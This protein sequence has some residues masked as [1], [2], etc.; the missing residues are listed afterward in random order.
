MS[1]AR[2]RVSFVAPIGAALMLAATIASDGA[3]ERFWPQWRGPHATGVSRHATPPIEWSETKNVRWKVEIPGR[4]SSSPVVWGD[5]LFLLSAVPVGVDGPASHQSR[6]TMQP[7]DVH[8]FIVLAIDRRT[9][10]VRWERIAQEERP[11]AP[12]MKDGTWASSSAIT[13]GS[14]VFAFFESSGLYAY[15]MDGSLLWQKRFG[16]KQMFA[17]VGE[18]G[19]TPVLYGDRLVVVWDH[20]G[21]SF[22][23]ALDARTGAE[24]WRKSRDEVD[25]W[26]TPL[27]VTHEGRAQVVTAAE[28]RLRSYDLATGD[29]V[30]ESNG[31]TMNPIPS[32]VSEGGLLFAMSGFKGNRLSAIRLAEAKGDISGGKANAWTLDRDTPYVPSPLLYD[33]LLYFLKSNAGILSVFDANTGRPHYQAQRLNGIPEVYSSPVA[34]QGR[35]YITGRDG[36]TAVLRQGP[37]FEMLAR[38]TL[39]DGFDASAALVDGH[40]YLRGYRYLYDI[41]ER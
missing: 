5:H 20:Q 35:V 15:N 23:V 14:R 31:L 39:D 41:A 4:G 40:I 2:R 30:W 19:S 22:I 16:N 8:R 32:P 28:K 7:R 9:G 3:G 33:G 36:T 10:R 17:E 27:V 13:D 21:E 24:L 12:S 38:N 6:S 25:S 26:A 37:R 11:R 29:I 1:N 34:A 18:S